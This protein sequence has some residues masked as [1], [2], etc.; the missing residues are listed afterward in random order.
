MQL[1]NNIK[2]NNFWFSPVY[3]ILICKDFP[4][5]KKNEP[6]PKN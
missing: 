2:K 4:L 6:E 3:S 1:I 5:I